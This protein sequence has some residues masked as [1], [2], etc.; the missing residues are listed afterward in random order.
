MGEGTGRRASGI[1]S[2]GRRETGGGIGHRVLGEEVHSGVAALRDEEAKL[3]LV[4]VWIR[5]GRRRSGS[6]SRAS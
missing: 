5:V 4:A 3:R 1:G 2:A 6:H